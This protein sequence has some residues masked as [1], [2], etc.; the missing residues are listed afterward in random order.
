[1]IRLENP[2]FLYLWIL[3]PIFYL[4]HYF[5]IKYKKKKLANFAESKTQQVIIPHLS[6]GKQHLKFT[7]WNLSFFFLVLAL[8]NPQ[9]GTSIEKKERTGTDLMV[10][11]DISNSMLAE[12]LKPNRISRAKQA[13]TQLINQ[14]EGDRIGVVVF[15]GTS[16][17]HL[18]ITSDYTAAKTFIDVIEPKLIELQGTS[19]AE[20]LE[21]A[22]SAFENQNETNRSRSIILI[23]DGEDNEDGAIEVS[24]EIAK[25]GVVINTIGLGQTEGTPIPIYDRHG[26]SDFKRDG[27]GNIVL[28]KLNET[29]LKEIAKEG[30]GVYIRAN[31][32]SIGLDDI[33]ARIN[34]MEKNE[35]EAVAYK[36]YDSKFYVFAIIALFF[37]LLEWVIF[38]KRN[39]YINRKLFFGNEK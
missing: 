2:Q 6:I 36:N 25:D 22:Y 24:K 27:N 34:K 13:L 8:A 18:P 15:A 35:Y 30:N 1:M 16:F 7:L 33:L 20:S 26:R 38:E 21:K 31:N 14:L 10:C 17:V 37:L 23:S 32:S 39:K 11:L 29:L 19:I 12:D 28:T 5:Y 9:K 3:I 4:L